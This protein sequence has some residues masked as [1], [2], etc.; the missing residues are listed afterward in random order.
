[1]FSGIRVELFAY[2]ASFRVPGFVGHQLTLQVPPIS[3]I[4]GLLSAAAGRRIKPEDVSWF[5]YVCQSEAVASDL[6]AITAFE[7]GKEQEIASPKTR[8]IIQREFL[9]FPRLFLY[10]PLEWRTVFYCPH[11]SLLLGRTQDVA[12][13][14]VIKEIKLEPVTEGEVKGVLF[15]REVIF[16]GSRIHCIVY[17]LPIAFTEDPNR[18]PLGV[19]LFGIVTKSTKVRIP[20]WLVQ[21]TD[22]GFVMPIY[23]REWI[24]SVIQRAIS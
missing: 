14:E 21:D 19:E 8:N 11:Y 5:A 1:M 9:A 23:R 16:Q 13:V 18:R 22:N 2:T 3:T 12:T 6:E 24:Q 4:Y 20:G 10:L 7:R 17:N 15:P